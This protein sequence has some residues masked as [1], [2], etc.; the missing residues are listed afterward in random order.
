M[1]EKLSPK[2]KWQDFGHELCHVL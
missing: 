2:G 1:N